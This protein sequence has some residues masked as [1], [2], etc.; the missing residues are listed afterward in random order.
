MNRGSHHKLQPTFLFFLKSVRITAHYNKYWNSSYSM[1]QRNR[2]YLSLRWLQLWNVKGTHVLINGMLRE[3]TF[4]NMVGPSVKTNTINDTNY[5]LG[6]IEKLCWT[7]FNFVHDLEEWG[8]SMRGPTSL[9]RITYLGKFHRS[10][11]VIHSPV[12]G[13]IFSSYCKDWAVML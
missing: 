3:G 4:L 9:C 8:T 7:G 1:T 13:A 5:S 12:G 2:I 11:A 10:W 6:L